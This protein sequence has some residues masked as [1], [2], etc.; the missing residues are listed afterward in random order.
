MVGVSSTM[1]SVTVASVLT[2]STGVPACSSAA[3][4][5]IEKHDAWAAAISCSGLAP[6]PSS[7]RDLNETSPW[8]PSPAEKLP[9]PVLSP[10]FHSAEA[11]A[12]MGLHLLGLSR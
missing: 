11:F 7:K 10:P 2:E 3:D 8:M 1:R 5:A 4:R 12:G 9:P 6:G